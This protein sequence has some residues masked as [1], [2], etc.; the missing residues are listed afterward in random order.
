VRKALHDITVG[1]NYANVGYG[2]LGYSAETGYD[3]VTGL[4]TPNGTYLKE[5]VEKYS[6]A[7]IIHSTWILGMT[8][9]ALFLF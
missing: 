1:N 7:S 3:L 8:L 4:G 2:D 5:V 6:S 9:V